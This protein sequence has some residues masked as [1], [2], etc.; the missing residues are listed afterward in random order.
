MMMVANVKSLITKILITVIAYL[1]ISN[2]GCFVKPPIT[3]VRN[4]SRYCLCKIKRM[5]THHRMHD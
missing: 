2:N 4:Y 1:P 3:D 5:Q